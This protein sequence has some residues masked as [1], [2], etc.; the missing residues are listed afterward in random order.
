[1]RT[2]GK[3]VETPLDV[4]AKLVFGQGGETALPCRSGVE[5][6]AISAPRV[7]V[8]GIGRVCLY[9]GNDTAPER[10]DEG[11]GCGDAGGLREPAEQ[12]SNIG[13]QREGGGQKRRQAHPECGVLGVPAGGLIL[14]DNAFGLKGPKEAE[15]GGLVEAEGG[16]QLGERPS[17]C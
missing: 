1:L 8:D 6:P 9:R 11:Q 14:V 3:W 12:R 15:R 16:T 17:R 4:I 2:V 10:I 5:R 7:G 13:G